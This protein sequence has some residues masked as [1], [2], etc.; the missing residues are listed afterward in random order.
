M[1]KGNGE[2]VLA[3]FS[4]DRK[5]QKVLPWTGLILSWK[6]CQMAWHSS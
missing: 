3:V 2:V 6:S 4:G 5:L 1:E